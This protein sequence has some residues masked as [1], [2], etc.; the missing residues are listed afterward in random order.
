MNIYD[1]AGNE[2]E[3]TLE[4]TSDSSYPCANRGGV[5]NDAGSDTPASYRDNS[6]TT[7]SDFNVGFRPALYVN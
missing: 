4:N 7:D 1:F 5:Y 6:Y 2:L 3:W